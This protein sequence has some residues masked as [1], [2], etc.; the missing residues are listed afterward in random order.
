[1]IFRHLRPFRGRRKVV[2]SGGVGDV[3]ASACDDLGL[4]L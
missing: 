4:E 1:M 3:V 2:K